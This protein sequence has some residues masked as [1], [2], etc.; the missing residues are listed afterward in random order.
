DAIADLSARGMAVGI[1]SDSMAARYG[2]RLAART[3]ADVET[4]ALLA[5]VW[6]AGHRPAVRELLAHA[7]RAFAI[8]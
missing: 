3:I 5:L 4:P 1:L 6:R 8:R 2:D 7:R